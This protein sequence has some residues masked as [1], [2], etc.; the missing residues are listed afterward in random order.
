MQLAMGLS[1]AINKMGVGMASTKSVAKE[2]KQGELVLWLI[3]S[4]KVNW[5]LRLVRLR[6]GHYSPIVFSELQNPYY[7]I[8]Q[9]FIIFC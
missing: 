3:E 9:R 1:F 8:K 6:N 5:E 2:V 4:A 7:Q